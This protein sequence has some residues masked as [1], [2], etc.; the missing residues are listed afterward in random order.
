MAA[1]TVAMP[2]CLIVGSHVWASAMMMHRK[3]PVATNFW[4]WQK[5]FHLIHVRQ[6][7]WMIRRMHLHDM[8]PEVQCNSCN[9]CYTLG[10][11]DPRPDI[12]CVQYLSKVHL[13]VPNGFLAPSGTSEVT[14]WHQRSKTL[15]NVEQRSTTSLDGGYGSTTSY[16]V[17]GRSSSSPIDVHTHG[18]TSKIHQ[19]DVP[20]PVES[21]RLHLPPCFG[22]GDP[23]K[24]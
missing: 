4:P 16:D 24:H 11:P 3:F 18:G 23:F 10:M 8:S 22:Q 1:F 21:Y 9:Y 14:D 5:S 20:T 7:R 15:L 17:E 19:K 6:M 13:K 2:E 12:R